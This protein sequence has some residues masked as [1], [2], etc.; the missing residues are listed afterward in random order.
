MGLI[1]PA[2]AKPSALTHIAYGHL[3]DVAIAANVLD[4]RVF[5]VPVSP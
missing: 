2:V 1:V 4:Y 3:A 5:L